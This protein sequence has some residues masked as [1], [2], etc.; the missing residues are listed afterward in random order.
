MAGRHSALGPD[1]AC[2]LQADF[3]DQRPGDRRAQQIHAFVLRL[4]LED[5]KGEVAAEFFLGVDEA[6]GFGA[7]LPCLFKNRLAVFAY[8]WPRST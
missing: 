5:G 1:F 8:G 4:P 3:R 7:D 2:D 6:G